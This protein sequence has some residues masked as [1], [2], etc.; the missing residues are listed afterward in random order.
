MPNIYFAL[1]TEKFGWHRSADRPSSS[2]AKW[3]RRLAA[4]I[5]FGVGVIVGGFLT[6]SYKKGLAVIFWIGTGLKLGIAVGLLWWRQEEH[7]EKQDN[8]I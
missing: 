7:Q 3:I 2:T 1:V 4:V 6:K 8:S 5:F